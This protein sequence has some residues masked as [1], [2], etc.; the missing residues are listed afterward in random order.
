[1]RL[2]E[3]PF[4]FGWSFAEPGVGL[5]DPCGSLPTSDIL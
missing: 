1:M 5:D 3:G 4:A 2:D